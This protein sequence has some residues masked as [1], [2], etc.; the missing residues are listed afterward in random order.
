MRDAWLSFYLRLYPGM[1]WGLASAI[2][3]P[4][5]LE[6]IMQGLYFKILPLLKVNRNITKAY[7]MFLTKYHGLEMPNFV[8]HRFAAKGF[9]SSSA[10]GALKPRWGQ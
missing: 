1:V 6:Q 10:S 7:R 4:A 5:K 8:V 2:I 9:F 3:K